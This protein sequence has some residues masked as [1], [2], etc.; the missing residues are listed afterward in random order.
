MLF[1]NRLKPCVSDL[2]SLYQ[3]SRLYWS[4]ITPR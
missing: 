1:K 2:R 4:F 3:Q